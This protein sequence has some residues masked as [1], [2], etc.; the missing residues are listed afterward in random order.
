MEWTFAWIIEVV[1]AFFG[2]F[3]LDLIC[4]EEH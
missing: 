3:V 4:R 1:G 2:V